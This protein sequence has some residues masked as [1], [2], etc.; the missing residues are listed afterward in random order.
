MLLFVQENGV[1]FVINGAT[2]HF[3]G[4]ITIVSADNPASTL[5]GGFKQSALP[6]GVVVIAWEVKK[7][8][9]PRCS[10]CIHVH[11]YIHVATCMLIIHVHVQT[12]YHTVQ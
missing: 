4:T 7:I 6:F 3:R 12:L 2:R 8:S 9:S 10:A 5:L 11:V 1:P